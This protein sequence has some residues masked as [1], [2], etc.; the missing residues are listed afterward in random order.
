MIPLKLLSGLSALTVGV[1]GIKLWDT[2][3]EISSTVP[4]PCR[5][6]LTQN[7]TC[8]TLVTP[9]QAQNGIHLPDTTAQE[10]CAK[11]C[12]DSVV[13]FQQRVSSACGH[14][15]YTFVK[16]GSMKQSAQAIAEGFSWAQKLMCIKDGDNFCLGDL[17]GGQVEKCSA[18]IFIY[19][20]VMVES[21]YGRPKFPEKSF[22][23]M[24]EDC[25]ADPVDYPYSYTSGPPGPST[26]ENPPSPSPTAFCQSGKK[27]KVKVGDTCDSIALANSVSSFR[28]IQVNNLDVA[29]EMLQ[30]GDEVCIRD[31]CKLAT[32][33]VNQTCSDFSEGTG[34]TSVQLE[35]WNPELKNKCDKRVTPNLNAYEGRH[36]C[37]GPP[38]N[39]EFPTGTSEWTSPT[40][41]TLTSSMF[42]GSWI[43]GSVE[44]SP[45]DRP[46]TVTPPFDPEL[47]P[48]TETAIG[49]PDQDE[50]MDEWLQYCWI[51]LADWEEGFHPSDLVPACRDFYDQYC[52]YNPEQP[53]PKPMTQFPARC[54][55]DRS[56]YGPLPPPVQTPSPIQNGVPN[57]CNKWH[58]VNKGELCDGIAKKHAISVSDLSKWNPAV[59]SDC[60]GLW[61]GVYICVGVRS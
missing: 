21:D 22:K 29:C 18:C 1:A 56:N 59:G 34:F 54:T 36:I 24:L 45:T 14:K 20:S 4:A 52:E 47:D 50:K 53:S 17:Y 19:G 11:G 60:S 48:P 32:I 26:T 38:G 35:S 28:L 42:T 30:V 33:K 58:F 46:I 16:D 8:E 27:Y 6:A 55:P 57:N 5:V 39:G 44:T 3:G 7:I 37:I 31:T 2:P 9:A 40:K 13:N 51:T 10:Y 41:A 49:N 12:R 61:A 15:L 43:T 23:A 25:N